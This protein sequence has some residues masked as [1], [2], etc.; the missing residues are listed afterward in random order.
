MI[1][2]VDSLLVKSNVF[3][4]EVEFIRAAS[5]LLLGL[6]LIDLKFAVG[7]V[8]G[9][10][11][12]IEGIVVGVREVGDDEVAGVEGAREDSGVGEAVGSKDGE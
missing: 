7:E 5:S 6:L 9:K 4:G 2:V 10:D 12:V 8:D 3:V 1:R 11:D